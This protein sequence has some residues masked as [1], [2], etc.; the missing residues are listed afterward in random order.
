MH[1]AD[2]VQALEDSIEEFDFSDPIGVWGPNNLVV[3]GHGRLLA[4]KKKGLTEVP[5]IHLDHLNEEQQRAYRLAHNRTAELSVWDE[6]TKK[7]ELKAIKNL[8][9]LDFGFNLDEMYDLNAAAE[10]DHQ[11]VKTRRKLQ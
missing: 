11:E 5:V 8:N 2:D 1:D 6:A 10:A 4:A 3:E 9:M 7:A